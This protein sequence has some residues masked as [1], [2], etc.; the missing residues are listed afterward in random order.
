MLHPSFKT[1]YYKNTEPRSKITRYIQVF[2]LCPEYLGLVGFLDK[3]FICNT[4]NHDQNR[5]Y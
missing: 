5:I 1:E 4:E 2:N 3:G